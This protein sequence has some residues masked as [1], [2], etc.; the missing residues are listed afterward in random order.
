MNSRNEISLEKVI[1]GLEFLGKKF[2]PVEREHF[3]EPFMKPFLIEEDALENESDYN[4]TNL[5][6]IFFLLSQ[7]SDLEKAKSLFR[8]YDDDKSCT[9]DKQEIE[10]MLTNLINIVDKYSDNIMRHDASLK[11]Y[12]TSPIFDIITDEQ[13]KT[14]E[15]TVIFCYVHF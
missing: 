6:A 3:L 12:N 2:T 8:F 7:S 14:K 13:R 15:K 11:G 5:M 4:F 10:K 1:V 9:L